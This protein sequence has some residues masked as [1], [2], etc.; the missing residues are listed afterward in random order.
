MNCG[1]VVPVGTVP[2]SRENEPVYAPVAAVHVVPRETGPVP[3][4]DAPVF[5]VAVLFTVKRL[6]AYTLST[7]AAAKAPA[8]TIIHRL[9]LS[10][11]P[12]SRESDSDVPNYS[13]RPP[14]NRW[15]G[16]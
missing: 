12:L 10:K 3:K 11:E 5:I 8:I 6:V 15:S 16:K 14:A 1:V 13:L 7:R 2:Q 4:S 9:L